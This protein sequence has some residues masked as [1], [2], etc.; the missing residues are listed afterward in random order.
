M[1]E[2]HFALHQSDD[3]RGTMSSQMTG[4]VSLVTQVHD[5]D[6][7]TFRA[8]KRHSDTALTGQIT[9]QSSLFIS[10]FVYILVKNSNSG[11]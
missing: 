5:A 3:G 10:K 7:N 8:N 1:K 4:Q 11:V 2:R 6:T 9:F